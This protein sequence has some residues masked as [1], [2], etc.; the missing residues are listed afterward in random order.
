MT[1]PERYAL[2]IVR[3]CGIGDLRIERHLEPF[4]KA[5]C[6]ALL[7]EILSKAPLASNGE[8]FRF[9]GACIL[10]QGEWTGSYAP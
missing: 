10:M 5:D 2:I 3:G 8:R 4:T 1:E 7:E 6:E 9:G